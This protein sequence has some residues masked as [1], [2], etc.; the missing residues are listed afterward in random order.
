MKQ[1]LN[2]TPIWPALSRRRPRRQPRMT[3]LSTESPIKGRPVGLALYEEV[4]RYTGDHVVLSFSL[5]K[6]SIGAWLALKDHFN[7]VP[8]YQYLIPGLSFVEEALSYFEERM[9]RHIY[10]YPHPSLYRMLNGLVFQPPDRCRIIE[11]AGLQEYGYDDL[12]QWVCEAEGLP[13][14][15]YSAI[16]VRAVDSPYRWMAL[17]KHGPITHSESKWYPVW[18][19]RKDKLLREIERARIKL[20]EDYK[21]FGRSFDGIDLRFLYPIKQHRPADYQKILD[22]FP[23]ADLEVYRYERFV[24]ARGG[25]P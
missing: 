20:P 19:W 25:S 13:A 7:V 17:K 3:L 9:G 21:L 10:R 11:A 24:A 23:L 14:R 5:G 18:D 8:V 4:R 16:G 15:T 1:A 22:W 6:D 2:L 12:R